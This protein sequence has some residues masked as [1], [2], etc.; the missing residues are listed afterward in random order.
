VT[1]LSRLPGAWRGHYE[2]MSSARAALGAVPAELGGRR[3]VREARELL[4]LPG[5]IA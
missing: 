5:G 1:V 3:P 4:A 2:V